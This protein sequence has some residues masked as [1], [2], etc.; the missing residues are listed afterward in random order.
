MHLKRLQ[1]DRSHCI[2]V[3][4]EVKITSALHVTWVDRLRLDQRRYRCREEL[5]PRR[6]AARLAPLCLH[7]SA[8]TVHTSAGPLSLAALCLHQSFHPPQYVLYDSWACISSC[9][10]CFSSV[11]SFCPVTYFMAVRAPQQRNKRKSHGVLVLFQYCSTSDALC[12]NTT[13]VASFHLQ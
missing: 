3:Y 11:S 10:Q 8:F 2:S 7:S 4:T 5:C 6:L 9:M 12:S 13:V 1:L